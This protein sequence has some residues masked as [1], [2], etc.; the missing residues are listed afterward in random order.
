[1]KMMVAT[2]AP[3][4]K[5]TR[6]QQLRA[7]RSALAQRWREGEQR[8]EETKLWW[9]QERKEINLRRRL[10]E[11]ELS[12]KAERDQR[13]QAV[14][15]W[16]NHLREEVAQRLVWSAVDG[17]RRPQ[18]AELLVMRPEWHKDGA[19]KGMA[20]YQAYA[21]SDDPH[22]WNSL[23]R[24]CGLEVPPV[25]FTKAEV[26]KIMEYS[27]SGVE[28]LVRVGRL[29]SETRGHQTVRFQPEDVRRFIRT[30]GKWGR[31]SQGK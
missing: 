6:L 20:R 13:L 29:Q 2:A 19:H 8:W 16:E 28:R 11:T 15:H 27:I 12:R 24:K 10:L 18:A 3:S 26:G 17:R 1:M 31:T 23:A 25:V 5:P 9:R 22:K 7:A 21:R 14:D 4:R 30:S